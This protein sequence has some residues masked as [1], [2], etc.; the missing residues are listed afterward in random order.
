[1]YPC[2]PNSRSARSR[3]SLLLS[4]VSQPRRRRVAR[5]VGGGEARGAIEGGARRSA[6]AR[7]DGARWSLGARLT[8][9]AAA[10]ARRRRR[11]TSMGL[12]I[13]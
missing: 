10:R 9:A 3:D 4:I 13:L 12:A 5:G 6:V 8:R 11:A 7:G 2:L 1:M